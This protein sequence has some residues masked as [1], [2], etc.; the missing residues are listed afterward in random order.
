M[1]NPYQQMVERYVAL[2]DDARRLP[3]GGIDEA[4]RPE[5][6]PEAPVVLIFSP[7]PDDE[8]IIGGMALR[9]LREQRMRVIN[10][11]VTQGSNLARQQPRWEELANACAYLGFELIPTVKNGLE[12]IKTAT[13]EQPSS[14][15]MEAVNCI[16]GI[17][18]ERRPH[19]LFLPH[20]GD[21]NS[22]HIGTH[23][24]V[25]D[26]LKQIS[27]LSCFVVETEFWGAMAHPNLMVESAP[28]EVADL[29]AALSFHV[30]EVK[31][32]PYHLNLPAWMQ[33]NVRRG[34]EIVGGQ[35]GA[36]PDFHFATLYRL[37][38]WEDGRMVPCLNAGRMLTSGDD[39]GALFA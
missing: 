11:A 18:E 38:R 17:L 32:N 3:L 13:R 2:M 28:E 24:L 26:A 25:M 8:C 12:D 14:R 33:D 4:A 34:G 36:V 20:A 21:W 27:G 5:I 16:A 30:E 23:Y 22:T 10:V 35:G 6:A 31:R 1:K 39:V 9:M 37:Q 7:H 19:T 29:I 15:W